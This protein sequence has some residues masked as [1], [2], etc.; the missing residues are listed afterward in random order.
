ME[1]GETE[2]I[3]YPLEAESRVDQCGYLPKERG[4]SKLVSASDHRYEQVFSLNGT[5]PN[6]Y[7][8]QTLSGV[9]DTLTEM[10]EFDNY[11]PDYETVK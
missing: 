3:L 10:P 6:E 2:Q 11:E 5:K 7:E 8:I 9:L 4:K 1:D